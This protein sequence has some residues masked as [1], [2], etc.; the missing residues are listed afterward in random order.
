MPKYNA[1]GKGS[2]ASR[3]YGR[4]QGVLRRT[5][6]DFNLMSSIADRIDTLRVDIKDA[7]KD[8]GGDDD[9]G[10]L[11]HWGAKV[12]DLEKKLATASAAASAVSTVQRK[13]SAQ[14]VA[15][16]VQEARVIR[17][18]E[19]E[20]AE[21]ELEARARV[22]KGSA[23]VQGRKEDDPY[24][25]S[26]FSQMILRIK[27]EREAARKAAPPAASAP[28]EELP[29]SAGAGSWVGS[30]SRFDKK[31]TEEDETDVWEMRGAKKAAPAA[32]A[33]AAA[34]PASSAA[35]WRS[36][37]APSWRSSAAASAAPAAAAVGVLP[38]DL[39]TILRGYPVVYK[40]LGDKFRVEYFN[41]KIESIA[42][43]RS[44]QQI[45][46]VKDD[47]KDQLIKALGSRVVV[48][49]AP[50]GFAFDFTVA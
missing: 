30:K 26:A 14:F 22:G 7:I 31:Y 44:L 49:E 17:A 15:P 25:L 45:Q 28:V 10:H 9:A 29:A 18:I 34:A 37:A 35:S 32:A 47:V 48:S 5:R 1:S 41:K 19:A 20:N 42:G 33:A 11:L 23:L 39:D 3:M 4:M 50:R 38:R 46:A 40:P 13:Q 8:D 36:A 2:D 12:V 24:F 6:E 21:I 43:G 27:A 16:S